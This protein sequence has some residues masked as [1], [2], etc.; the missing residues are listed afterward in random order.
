MKELILV[1]AFIGLILTSCEKENVEPEQAQPQ[2][3]NTSSNSN[4]GGSGNNNNGGNNSND[5]TGIEYTFYV[6]YYIACSSCDKNDIIDTIYYRNITTGDST[7]I[8]V[9]NQITQYYP[10]NILPLHSDS[11]YF[12][13]QSDNAYTQIKLDNTSEG[14]SIHVYVK[15]SG[16]GSMWG[17]GI[18]QH[19]LPNAASWDYINNVG[20]DLRISEGFIVN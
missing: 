13:G 12:I 17:C 19:D 4:N 3:N 6:D 5:T 20:S 15:F 1:I 7:L 2:Q 11:V 14:D 18:Y 10:N 16:V 8:V 9:D